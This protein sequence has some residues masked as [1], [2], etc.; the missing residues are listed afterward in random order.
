MSIAATLAPQHGAAL[1]L[2]DKLLQQRLGFRLLFAQHNDPAYRDRLLAHLLERTHGGERLDLQSLSGF[3][4]FEDHLAQRV[5]QVGAL[6]VINLES[7]RADLRAEFLRG[8]NYHR[9]QLAAKAPWST[10]FWLT[11]ASLDELA[12]QAPDFWA[13]REQVLDFS[14][15]REAQI[16]QE[17]FISEID[18][19]DSPRKQQR[20]AELEAYFAGR[21]GG[22]TLAEVDMLAELG[23][24]YWSVG[25]YAQA[26]VRL[27]AAIA[28]YDTLGEVLA[29]AAASAD[30]ARILATTGET[31][32]A[33]QRLRTRCLPVFERLGD[34]RS[35]A[36][37]L[38]Q[39]A[40]I[41]YD[42]GEF[43]EA[44]RIRR[45]EVLPVYE[46]LGDVRSRAVTLGQIADILYDRG[47]L[48]EALELHD[49]CLPIA[50]RLGDIEML[51]AVRHARA[52]IRWLRGDQRRDALPVIRDD[53]QQSFVLIRK[54]GR[55]DA[56]AAVGRLYAQ[57]LAADGEQAQALAVLDDVEAAWRKLDN[58][59][60]LAQVQALRRTIAGQPVSDESSASR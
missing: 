56:I 54:L 47:E 40:D 42:R 22:E 5:G 48:D 57:V 32:Q 11:E 45:E 37:T 24:L 39:I 26:R 35:R 43:D 17:K 59:P 38:G 53:L 2:L 23:R 6:H 14:L 34:V 55:P 9:E 16:R 28:G 19:R 58:A 46:R 52:A 21:A 7:L 27:E 1:L 8:L 60:G 29:Q 20:V 31:T 44:L 49:A 50:E 13:W 25:D 36:V 10:V 51:A 4:A 41:L 15:P 18:N 3:G 33:L 12:R 30:L